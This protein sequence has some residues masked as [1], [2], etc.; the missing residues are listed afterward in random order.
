VQTRAALEPSATESIVGE[1]AV[2]AIIRASTYRS[3]RHAQ[4]RRATPERV[5]RLRRASPERARLHRASPERARLHRAIAE[6]TS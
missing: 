5:T 6:R 4:L 3:E 2:A 1:R